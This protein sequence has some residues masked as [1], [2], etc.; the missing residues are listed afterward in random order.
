MKRLLLIL[1][2]ILGTITTYAITP[3]FFYGKQY[4]GM[5]DLS[6]TQFAKTKDLDMK[7]TIKFNKNSD[8]GILMLDMIPKTQKMADLLSFE[9]KEKTNPRVQFK[10]KISDGNILILDNSTTPSIIY[11]GQEGKVLVIDDNPILE[12]MSVVLEI[13][14]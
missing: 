13:E 11:V 1:V 14:N 4:S 10:Y 6:N 2:V 12:G 7:L 5:V 9:S 3:S 8:S